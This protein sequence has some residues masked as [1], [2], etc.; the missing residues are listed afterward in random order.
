MGIG[1]ADLTESWEWYRK[2]FGMDCRIFEDE[3]EAKLMLPYTGGSQEADMPY[4]PLT[5]KA[6]AVS[7]YGN[8]RGGNQRLHRLRY[9]PATLE[10]LPA[11]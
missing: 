6:E 9:W 10:Y 3:A 8:I 7:K 11:K 5:F 4:W 2:H 1:V